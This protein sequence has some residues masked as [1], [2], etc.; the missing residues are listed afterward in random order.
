MKG[1]VAKL[2]NGWKYKKARAQRL[3]IIRLQSYNFGM[4][5]LSADHEK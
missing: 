3:A 1:D 5:M 2:A 4:Y